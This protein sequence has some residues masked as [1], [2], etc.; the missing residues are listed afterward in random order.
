[1]TLDPVG[2]LPPTQ[3]IAFQAKPAS[4]DFGTWLASAIGDVNQQLGRAD[5]AV[6][7]LAGGETQKA[8]FVLLALI[9]L[10]VAVAAVLWALRDDYQPLFTELDPRDAAAITAE[11]ERMK[12]PYRIG[13]DGATVL[14]AGDRVHATRLKVMGK[15]IDLKGTVGFEI[16]NTSDFGMTEFAQRINY[17]RALQGELARTIMAFEE[18]KSAR[19]HVVLPETGA[20]RR[21]AVRPKASVTLAMRNDRRLLPEQIQGIQR[22]V[23]AAV[24]EMDPAAVTVIDH[25]GVALSRRADPGADAEASGH[26]DAKRELESYLARKVVAVLDKALGPGQG[27][28]SVDVTLNHDHVKVTREDVLGTPGNAAVLRR[29]ESVQPGMNAALSP[30][31][32]TIKSVQPATSTEVEYS[33]GRKV[34]QVV[35]APGGIRRVSVGVLLPAALETHQAESLKQVIAMAVG[36]NP[37]RGDAI[38]LSWAGG[39]RE[40]KPVAPIEPRPR[41]RPAAPEAQGIDWWLLLAALALAAAVALMVVLARRPR[42]PAPLSPKEREE[43]LNRLKEWTQSG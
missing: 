38:A 18:V 13:D 29:R 40:A 36:L 19:V 34:E 32:D 22:L 7:E 33:L 12:V 24:P 28:V 17:Q 37:G 5:R 3:E 8:G 39:E 21:N 6:R 9:I 15:G 31:A 43:M 11:L 14:V 42:R 27:I 4:P 35:S 25:Q 16:F 23:A 10:G 2:Y 41:A 30:A 20:F 26:L 1:M